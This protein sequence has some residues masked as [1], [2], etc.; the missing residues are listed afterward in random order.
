MRKRVADFVRPIC[1]A[2]VQVMRHEGHG[3]DEVVVVGTSTTGLDPMTGRNTIEHHDKQIRYA[4]W[5]FKCR[6]C[7]PL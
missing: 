6:T 1:D 2:C 4:D 7:F 3:S 5:E